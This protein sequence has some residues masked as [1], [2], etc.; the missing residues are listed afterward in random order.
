MTAAVI[1]EQEGQLELGWVVRG[2]LGVLRRRGLDLALVGL[3]FV[4]L[5][6]VLVAFIPNTPYSI[7]LL[8]NL[9]AMLFT[10]GATW[11][12]Y[13]DLAGGQRVTAGEAIRTGA[14][15]FGGIWGV[16]IVSGIGTILGLLLLIVPGIILSLGWMAAIPVTVV[17]RKGV[18]ASLDR[19]WTLTRGSRW[20]LAGL[21][22]IGVVAIVLSMVL[23]I[24]PMV[25]M[26][27]TV[28]EPAATTI[29]DF[30]VT[31]L[32]VLLVQ[33]ILAVGA[34]SAYVGLRK[35]KEGFA[36]DISEVFA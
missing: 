27:A 31:P 25:V 14:A 32:W 23:L 5:P 4:V 12:T 28:G 3:P 19:A 21:L 20:R 26:T 15:R 16:S 11:I 24:L 7:Q 17:E 35:A 13:R 6:N 29:T 30:V 33:A 34:A 8:T 22:A 2:V 36:D 9:P 18:T 10:G 1:G